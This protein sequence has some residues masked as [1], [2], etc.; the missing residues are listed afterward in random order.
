MTSKVI[1]GF[2]KSSNFSDN[3]TLPNTVIYETILIKIYMNANITGAR[4][5]NIMKVRV[6]KKVSI[7]LKAPE[8]PLFKYVN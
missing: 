4:E 7:L 5:Q 3:P 8:A 6:R 2:K 1:E